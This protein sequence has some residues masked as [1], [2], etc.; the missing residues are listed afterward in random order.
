MSGMYNQGFIFCEKVKERLCSPDDYQAFLKCL[1][2]YSNGIIKRND[3]Q[4][5]V[6]VILSCNQFIMHHLINLLTP[7]GQLK[8]NETN[9][10]K[11]PCIIFLDL[12]TW[13]VF[14]CHWFEYFFCLSAHSGD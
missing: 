8:E 5:L 7:Y 11:E 10:I 9:I 4:N 12:V 1:N 3:L 6:C 13:F 2:I 14:C